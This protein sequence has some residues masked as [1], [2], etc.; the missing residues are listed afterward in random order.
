MRHLR[1]SGVSINGSYQKRQLVNFGYYHG[2]K[3]YRFFANPSCKIAYSD[4]KQL[5]AVIKFDN[6]LKSLFYPHLM[7]IE[8]ALK[9]ITLDIVLQEANSNNFNDIFDQLM[10][11]YTG[12][13]VSASAEQ[14]KNLK[15]KE[16]ITA[17]QGSLPTTSCL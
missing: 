16:I 14:K 13:W 8:T 9:N 4:F 7:F 1:D 17:K 6:N 2:Y 11:G 12:A 3:G 5:L 10:P 15:K